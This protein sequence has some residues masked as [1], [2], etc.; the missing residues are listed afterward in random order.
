MVW[1]WLGIAL[2]EQ[3]GDAIVPVPCEDTL[4]WVTRLHGPRANDSR[5][6]HCLDQAAE[7]LTH[8]DGD[9]PG[10]QRALAASG[11]VR[12]SPD[13]R[14]LMR[15]IAK[16]FQLDALDLPWADGPRLWSD[17]DIERQVPLFAKFLPAADGLAKGGAWD[18]TKHPRWPAGSPEGGEF[19]GG[20]GGPLVEGLPV[21]EKPTPPLPPPRPSATPLPPPRPPGLALA[22]AAAHVNPTND[23]YNCAHIIDAVVARLRGTDPNA[24]ALTGYDGRWEDIE[25]RLNTKFHLGE[26]L[27]HAYQIVAAGGNGAIG[28]I[29]MEFSDGTAHVVII[30]NDHGAVGIVE[31]QEAGQSPPGVISSLESANGLY[32]RD[33]QTHFRFGIL[34]RVQ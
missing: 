6:L 4:F 22:F 8:G 32:N 24:T 31:G 7:R 27:D 33:G 2:T 18:E 9:E 17:V 11:L 23:H 19:K 20:E 5:V 28:I 15:A 21:V 14:V 1:L 26:R 16:K 3:R 34:P 12:L 30:A 29:G 10:A 13:G 25:D